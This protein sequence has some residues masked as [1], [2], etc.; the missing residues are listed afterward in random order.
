MFYLKN[1]KVLITGGTGSL[2]KSLI[3]CLF[4]AGVEKII[5]FSRNE[6][7]QVEMA[8]KYSR[9]KYPI[10]YFLGDIRDENRLHRAFSGIDVVINCAAIK[11]VDKAQYDPFEVVNTNIIGVQNIIDAAINNGIDKVINIGTD[12]ELSPVSIYGASKLCATFLFIGANNYSPSKTKFS[13]VRFGNFWN[14][15]GSIVEMLFNMER[16]CKTK[17]PLTDERMTRFFITLDCASSFIINCIDDMIG[18]EIFIPKMESRKIV[19]VIKE[20]RPDL[21]YEIIGKRPGEKLHEQLLTKYDFGSKFEF[22]EYY[23]H[24]YYKYT[25]DIY[26]RKHDVKILDSEFECSSNE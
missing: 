16:N 26:K 20:I 6:Y 18:G 19:D 23:V 4:K 7:L 1:K 3:P 9:K 8:R 14:S 12:K 5:I 13:V 24:T 21:Q 25:S 22:P 15:S 17:M 2:G 10:R 11:H